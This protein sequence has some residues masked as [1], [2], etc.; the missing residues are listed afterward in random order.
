MK[1]LLTGATGFIG[2]HFTQ[3]NTSYEITPFSFQN[4]NINT[5]NVSGY[6]AVLHLAALVHQ[7]N[8]A[9]AKEYEQVNT[10][11]TLEL[12]HKAKADGVKQFIFMSTIKVYGEE[13][14]TAYTETTPCYPQDAYGKSKLHAEQELQKLSNEH[15]AVSIIRT[16]IV[17]GAGVKANIRNLID[18]IQNIPILPFGN[19]H[20]HRSM[21]YVGNLCALIDSVLTQEAEGIFLACDDSLLS[22]SDFIRK[23][24]ETLGKRLYLIDMP[25]FEHILK[26]FKPSLHQRLFGNLIVDNTWTKERLGFYNPYST[27]EG[28]KNMLQST[29]L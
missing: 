24:A 29:L 13:S 25:L 3:H 20:N 27:D 23:I 6:D 9:D 22:T 19:T 7:M 26:F 28:I 14:D 16:P 12:A 4:G 17:Y 10:I 5:L 11:R 2:S 15:F 18:L 1:I 21:V 8:G